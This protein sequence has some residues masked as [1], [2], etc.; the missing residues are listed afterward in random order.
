MLDSPSGREG[1][2]LFSDGQELNHGMNLTGFLHIK[3]QSE[4]RFFWVFFYC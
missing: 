1:G 3:E 2:Y 4:R